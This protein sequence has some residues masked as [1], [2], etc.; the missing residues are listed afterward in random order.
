MSSPPKVAIVHEWISSRAGSE[1]V[2]EVLAS[3]WPEADLFALSADPRVQMDL[4]GRSV[5]TT[6]L[7]RAALRDRRSLT[8]PLMPLAWRLIGRGSYDLVI[9]SHHAFAAS[10]RLASSRGVNLAYVHTPARYIWTPEL[11]GRGR[12]PLLVPVRGALK[13]VDRGY[14]DRLTGIAANSRAVAAR[15]ETFWGREAEVVHPPV[16]TEFFSPGLDDVELD[17]PKQFLL[18]FGRWIPY[19]NLETVIR[20]AEQVGMPAV[21]AGRGPQKEQLLAMA[22]RAKVPVTV[23]ESPSQEQVRELYRRAAALV[24]PTNED[25]GLIPVEAMACGT[26]VLAL[27]AG[28]ASET[29]VDGATGALVDS[30]DVRA[31]SDAL[32]RALAA[33]A[34]TC[35]RRA[36]EFRTEAFAR[37][38]RAWVSASVES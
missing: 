38:V 30:G 13:H 2:F 1:K 3:M 22:A 7:N 27:N 32:P 24:F 8:L 4:N 11:D 9:S 17:L 28:G 10:N 21:I 26:P 23:I 14:V 19:K 29:V 25:F 15:I 31:Y 33:T 35:R 18:G 36:E 12:S 20:V 16:D 34:A 37:R 5:R 6:F